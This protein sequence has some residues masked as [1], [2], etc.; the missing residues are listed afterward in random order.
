MLVVRAMRMLFY[1][2]PYL[3][4]PCNGWIPSYAARA[5]DDAVALVHT[6]AAAGL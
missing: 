3:V 2:Q 1:P 4:R 5:L 6:L